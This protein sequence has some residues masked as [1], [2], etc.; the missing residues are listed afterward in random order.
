MK[1]RIDEVPST[2]LTLRWEEPPACLDERLGHK[3]TDLF[4]ART[5][6]E[7]ALVAARVGRAVAVVGRVGAVVGLA[8][9]RCLR[10]IDSRF[11]LQVAFVFVPRR[12]RSAS[13]AWDRSASAG[14]NRSA[15]TQDRASSGRDRS[16]S[17]RAPRAEDE[18]L[19]DPLDWLDLSGLPVELPGDD[20]EVLEYMG[21]EIDLTQAVV[22]QVVLALPLQPRCRDACKGLCP[23]CG[24]DLNLGQCGCADDQGDPR[25]AAST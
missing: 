15:S 21:P 10:S 22:D 3:S 20:L 13:A 7:A 23:C 16:A 19:D 8:C 17:G 5:P 2:G 1:V 14:G 6:I 9:G 25:L 24:Y 12:E 4:E 11:D 18:E